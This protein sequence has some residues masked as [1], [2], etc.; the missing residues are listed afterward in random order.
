VTAEIRKSVVVELSHGRFGWRMAVGTAGPLELRR[1]V[2]RQ[3]PR[4]GRSPDPQILRDL[5][6]LNTVRDH[7]PDQSPSFH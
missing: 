5:T 6:L 1:P 2:R 4:N 7:P 3:L